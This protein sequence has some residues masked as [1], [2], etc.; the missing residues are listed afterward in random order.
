MLNLHI[1]S[2]FAHYNARC[3]IFDIS[4]DASGSAEV[5][6]IIYN[7]DLV[8]NHLLDVPTVIAFVH[9]VSNALPPVRKMNYLAMVNSQSPS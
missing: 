5:S 4:P 7:L 6:C 1:V 9:G 8:S 2:I 3:H